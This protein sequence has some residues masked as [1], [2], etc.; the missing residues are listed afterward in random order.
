MRRTP[1]S[2]ENIGYV[3]FVYKIHDTGSD[4][5]LAIA[6]SALLGKTF[7]EGE[8]EVTISESFYGSEKCFADKALQLARSSTIVNAMG[9]DV[10]SLLAE[11]KI[12]EKNHVL[13]VGKIMHA[14]VVVIA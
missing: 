3:M 9:N 6:D 12:V 4:K 5:M 14:Q 8:I 1:A 11:N 7:S 2:E 13:M 10:V